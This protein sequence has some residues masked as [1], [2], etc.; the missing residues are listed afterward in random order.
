MHRTKRGNHRKTGVDTVRSRYEFLTRSESTELHH[1]VDD[2]LR[3]ALIQTKL[4]HG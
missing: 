1:P 3:L 2:L 4:A